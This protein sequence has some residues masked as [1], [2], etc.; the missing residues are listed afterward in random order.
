[1]GDERLNGTRRERV[2]V[3]RGWK[4]M[5]TLLVEGA[6]IQCNFVKPHQGLEGQTPAEVAGI[7]VEGKDKWMELLM[8]AKRKT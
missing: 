4:S 5:K 1:M 8:A 2:K 7:R 3:Q 6:R